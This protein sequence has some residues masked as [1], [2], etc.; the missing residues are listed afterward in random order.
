MKFNF[1]NN[2]PI[3]IQLVEQIRIL[4]LFGYFKLGDRLPSVR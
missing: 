3:Y 1:D 4:I 2:R